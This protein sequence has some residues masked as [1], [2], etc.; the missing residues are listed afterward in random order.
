MSLATADDVARPAKNLR[1]N[2]LQVSRLDVAGFDVV[3]TRERQTTF[4]HPLMLLVESAAA[5][6][7]V[8]LLLITRHPQETSALAKPNHGF[9][10]CQQSCKKIFSGM[11][12]S[13]C[14]T[15]LVARL[16]AT[17]R[18][19]T[20]IH[21]HSRNMRHTRVLMRLAAIHP[22]SFAGYAA[23]LHAKNRCRKNAITALPRKMHHAASSPPISRRTNMFARKLREL[24][25]ALCDV[26]AA[27]VMPVTQ[28]T[29]T[30]DVSV[31]GSRSTCRNAVSDLRFPAALRSHPLPTTLPT[32]R[33]RPTR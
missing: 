21:M 9:F 8:A 24:L 23:Q 5:P 10:K 16:F 7:V 2:T 18:T 4:V 30:R 6:F 15:R 25:A 28:K 1:R 19:S 31:A 12:S 20:A 17:T 33:C 22:R 13:R 11:P 29:K 14:I 32:V 3:Q 27:T 26:N